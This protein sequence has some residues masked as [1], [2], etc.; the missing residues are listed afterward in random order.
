MVLEK[1]FIL[2]ALE[3]LFPWTKILLVFLLVGLNQAKE[4]PAE[5]VLVS[6][7]YKGVYATSMRSASPYLGPLV[8]FLL[9]LF[10]DFATENSVTLFSGLTTTILSFCA[11]VNHYVIMTLATDTG[12]PLVPRWFFKCFPCVCCISSIVIIIEGNVMLD[13]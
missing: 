6:S 1:Y 11:L 13:S 8:L 2:Q 10:L 4:F 3:K 12:S 9:G 7:N 5:A